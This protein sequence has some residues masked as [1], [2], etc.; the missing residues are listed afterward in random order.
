MEKQLVDIGG[1]LH[2]R[3]QIQDQH[4]GL[5]L[6]VQELVDPHETPTANHPDIILSFKPVCIL[7]TVPQ[8]IYLDC[9]SS[10]SLTFPDCKDL[11]GCAS[12]GLKQQHI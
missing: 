7:L 1:E 2:L 10:Q 9:V 11:K 12:E 4:N 5:P 3:K 8:M 6:K